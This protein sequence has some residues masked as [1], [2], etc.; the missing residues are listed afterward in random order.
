[1][2]I[3]LCHLWSVSVRV[4]STCTWKNVI[5]NSL[6][7]N[8]RFSLTDSVKNLV[9]CFYYER[10]VDTHMPAHH[11]VPSK[12]NKSVKEATKFENLISLMLINNLRTPY[13]VSLASYFRYFLLHF[14]GRLVK[15]M[16][17]YISFAF[18]NILSL[19][20]FEIYNLTDPF[21]ELI[22]L[23]EYTEY[24]KWFIAHTIHWSSLILIFHW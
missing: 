23:T 15:V 2:C 24:R 18:G 5:H 6:V 3:Y 16:M 12:W 8:T 1:M 4:E 7:E 9:T 11:F 19:Q 20:F 13:V 14:T 10:N 17:Q 22:H 21:Q